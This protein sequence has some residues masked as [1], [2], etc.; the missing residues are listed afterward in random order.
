[1]GQPAQPDVRMRGFQLR[2]EVDAVL[3]V[4]DARLRLLDAEAVEWERQGLEALLFVFLKQRRLRSSIRGK[5]STRRPPSLA[6]LTRP[7]TIS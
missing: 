6:P 5:T 3:Q 4:L 1:M 2:S 7:L